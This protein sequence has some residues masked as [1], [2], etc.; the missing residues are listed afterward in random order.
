M[1]RTPYVARMPGKNSTNVVWIN[2]SLHRCTEMESDVGFPL[3]GCPAPKEPTKRH[4]IAVLAVAAVVLLA[5]VS[6]VVRIWV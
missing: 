6:S 1:N 3:E 4:Y 2:T 5:V